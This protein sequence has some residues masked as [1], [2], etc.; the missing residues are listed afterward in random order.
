MTDADELFE[1]H[2]DQANRRRWAPRMRRDIPVTQE[3]ITLGQAETRMV[4]QQYADMLTD[5]EHYELQDLR[6]Q[7][8]AI[9]LCDT[10]INEDIP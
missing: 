9:P 5:K 4:Q 8:P 6:R 7:Y 2:E 10:L 1:H 3:D